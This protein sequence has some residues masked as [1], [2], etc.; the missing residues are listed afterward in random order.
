VVKEKVWKGK[1]A[2]ARRPSNASQRAFSQRHFPVVV[3]T[4]GFKRFGQCFALL[5]EALPLA[6]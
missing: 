4:S 3:E 2:C 1:A 5:P 6:S